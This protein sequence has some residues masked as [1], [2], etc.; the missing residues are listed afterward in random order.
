MICPCHFPVSFAQICDIIVFGHNKAITETR[1]KGPN[2]Q[3]LSEHRSNP[4]NFQT[5]KAYC[6]RS[7]GREKGLWKGIDIGR[8]ILCSLRVEKIR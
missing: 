5:E 6:H 4:S 8:Y 7:M 3:G 2:F 1:W